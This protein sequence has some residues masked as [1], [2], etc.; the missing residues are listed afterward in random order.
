[1][2]DESDL[3]RFI[4]GDCTPEEAAAI[5]AWI[6]ADPRRERLLDDLRALWRLTGD[7]A[8]EWDPAEARRRIVHPRA[9]ELLPPAR[10]SRPAPAW[11]AG[12]W[13][14]RAA[15]AAGLVIA[16]ATFWILGTRTAP[17]REYATAPGQRTEVRLPDGSRVVLAVDTRLRVPEDY[18]VRKRVVELEGE[19]YF[20]VR[21]DARRPFMVRTRHGTTEDLGTE[22][23]VRAYPREGE[24]QVVVA[25][26]SVAI[27]RAGGADPVALT[28]GPRDRAV[29]DARGGA[30]LT[31]GV[32]LENHI[33][34]L[35]GRLVFDDAPLR[36]VVA[37][38]ERWY[39]LEI[40]SEPSLDD[41]R[42][43][44][45]FT[46]ESP[47]QALTALAKV[48]NVR[49]SRAGR[50]VRLAPVGSRQ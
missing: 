10:P 17:W 42:L 27:R 25:A 1:M 11:H 20:I 30:T 46:T 39:D 47:D 15:V 35:R 16:G 34:W 9:L 40:R 37:Q 41:E 44:V 28:L 49:V 13:P 12:P 7:T 19:A 18:G 8:R 21:H 23:D 3:L 32:T 2:I 26:G 22:F 33:A 24:L 6:V 45:S 43:T 14:L 31:T 5:Q 38:L 4:E 36:A 48:L 29:I 50:S